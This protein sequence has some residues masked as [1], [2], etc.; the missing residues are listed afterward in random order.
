M[1]AVVSAIATC[2]LAA[3]SRASS[4]ARTLTVC[5]VAQS[6]AVKVRVWEA[7]KLAPVAS[8]ASPA[9]ALAAVTTTSPC[10][11]DASA[12]V[13][14][15]SAPPSLTVTA[16]PDSV[17]PAASSSVVFTSALTVASRS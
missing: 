4:T 1:L 12:T 7:A 17:S 2:S 13:K 9:A 8:S 5:A 14:R 15:A 16:L 6:L 10:G 11:R 3:S